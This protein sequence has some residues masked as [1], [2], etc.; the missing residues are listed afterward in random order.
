[1]LEHGPYVMD[2]GDPTIYKNP[3]AWNMFSNMIYLESPGGVGFST[4]GDAAD[5][6]YDDDTTA[7]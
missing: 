5:C 2:D 6:T 7:E 3:Y 4:C 1:L